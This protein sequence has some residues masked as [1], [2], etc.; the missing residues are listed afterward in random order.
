MAT[1]TRTRSG[2]SRR[3]PVSCLAEVSGSVRIAQAYSL[4]FDFTTY[5]RNGGRTFDIGRQGITRHHNHGCLTNDTMPRRK[6]AIT[7]T[8][9]YFLNLIS[10]KSIQTGDGKCSMPDLLS[11]GNEDAAADRLLKT[12]SASNPHRLPSAVPTTPGGAAKRGDT[13]A[14]KSW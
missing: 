6:D 8:F 7:V 4:P 13:H 10:S 5:R 2:C 12:L 11:A 1:R 3:L 9:L 14:S